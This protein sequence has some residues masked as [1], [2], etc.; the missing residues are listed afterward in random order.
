[1]N[2]LELQLRVVISGVPENGSG[3]ALELSVPGIKLLSTVPPEMSPPPS[4][5]PT[6]ARAHVSSPVSF[7]R[8]R[9]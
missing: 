6:L 4:G 2:I 9:Y 5:G 3:R 7:Q 8:S 1:M